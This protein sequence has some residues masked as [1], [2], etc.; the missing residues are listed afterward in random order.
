MWGLGWEF[1]SCVCL[2]CEVLCKTREKEYTPPWHPSF[3]GLSPDPEVTEQQK[4]MVYH[5]P[6]KA[7]EKGIH[8]LE[9]E[10]LGP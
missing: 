1:F 7:R 10:E 6:G 9:K 8:H 4:A 5:F 2:F 3:L